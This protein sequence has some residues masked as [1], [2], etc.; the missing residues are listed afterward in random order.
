MEAL[1][2]SRP[3]REAREVMETRVER[4]AVF[5]FHSSLGHRQVDGP[6]RLNTLSQAAVRNAKS[7]RP[8]GQAVRLAVEANI[9]IQSCVLGLLKVVGPSAVLRAVSSVVVNAVEGLSFRAWPHVVHESSERTGPCI[10]YRDASPAVAMVAVI[11]GIAASTDHA[12]PATEVRSDATSLRCPVVSDGVSVKAS[13]TARVAGSQRRSGCDDGRSAGACALPQSLLVLSNH[14]CVSVNGQ[15][16]EFSSGNVYGSHFLASMWASMMRLT[17]S[18]M[19]IPRRLA[20]RFKKDLCGSV[21]EIICLVMYVLGRVNIKGPIVRKSP[22]ACLISQ[23]TAQLARDLEY[24]WLRPS[25][26]PFIVAEPLSSHRATPF[27]AADNADRRD[28]KPTPAHAAGLVFKLR[29]RL[30]R[31]FMIYVSA[32]LTV[33]NNFKRHSLMI[34]QGIQREAPCTL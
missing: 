30:L 3:R 5:G 16:S 32:P 10:A 27:V 21:N 18:A 29:S 2:E 12:L 8:F 19:E 13:T 24:R 17:S 15:A 14:A 9:V 6:S 33:V 31:R 4:L 7:T 22:C 26:A 34:P 20:S 1:R 25:R 28:M 23:G 11:Q